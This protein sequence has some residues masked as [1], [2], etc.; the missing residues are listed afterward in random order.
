MHGNAVGDAVAGIQD[1]KDNWNLSVQNVPANERAAPIRGLIP[2]A[3]ST[4]TPVGA[5]AGVAVP[6]PSPRA[7]SPTPTPKGT[8][9]VVEGTPKEKL[10]NDMHYD[11]KQFMHHVVAGGNRDK[12][13]AD[14]DGQRF[15]HMRV[16]RL[17]SSTHTKKAEASWWSSSK[18][19]CLTKPSLA[20][21]GA[22]RWVASE[23]PAPTIIRGQP[24]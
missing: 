21:A 23:I 12:L 13:K 2:R 14:W 22:L 8:K 17:I 15:G 24:K 9:P 19:N 3:A 10:P 7:P 1:S 5:A 11:D 20:C 4:G 6:R 16:A 18:A